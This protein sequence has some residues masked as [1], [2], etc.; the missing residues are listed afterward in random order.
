MKPIPLSV[1]AANAVLALFGLA[2][3]EKC[4]G[5]WYV[6]G[7]GELACSTRRYGWRLTTSRE[8]REMAPGETHLGRFI[9]ER[10][11]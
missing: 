10:A 8:A 7:A 4:I 9:R 1:T 3:V 2:I 11:S 5:H 6:D